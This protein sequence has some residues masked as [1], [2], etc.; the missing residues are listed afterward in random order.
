MGSGWAGAKQL[1][2]E[3]QGQPRERMPIAFIAG[4]EGPFKTAPGQTLVRVRIGI[5]IAG[6][7]EVDEP[8]AQGP[9]KDQEYSHNQENAHCQDAAGLDCA[10][11]VRLETGSFLR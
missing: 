10:S 1:R 2:V 4:L 5:E 3:H 8:I 11:N 9:A 7:I 6:V